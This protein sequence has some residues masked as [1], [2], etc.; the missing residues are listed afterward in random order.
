MDLFVA[1]VNSTCRD[2]GTKGILA[3]AGFK[4]LAL[5]RLHGD[6]AFGDRFIGIPSTC[7]IAR[8]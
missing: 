4:D 6:S 7:V 8:I 1:T 5:I 2:P 3:Q